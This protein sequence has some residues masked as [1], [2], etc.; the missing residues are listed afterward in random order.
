MCLILVFFNIN[1]VHLRRKPYIEQ[2]EK[3]YVRMGARLI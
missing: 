3:R 1:S 2:D